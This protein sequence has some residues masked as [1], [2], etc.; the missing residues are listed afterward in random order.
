MTDNNITNVT[1]SLLKNMDRLISSKTVVGE[2]VKV[3]DTV[4]IPLVDVSFGVAA[5][6]V[7]RDKKNSGAGGM[8]AKLTASAV[9]MVQDG[10]ARIL[11][12]KNADSVSKIVDL[13]PE[14]IDKMK[15]RKAVTAD[16]EEAKAAAFPEKNEEEKKA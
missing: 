14:V 2:P 6:A 4:I 3:G 7:G 13:I 10:H 9:L 12:V 16:E 5:G 15:A 8:N 11:S 1:D